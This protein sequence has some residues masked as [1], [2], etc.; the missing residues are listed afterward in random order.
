M[1][2]ATTRSSKQSGLPKTEYF[3]PHFVIEVEGRE[4]RPERKAD[5]TELK[6]SLGIEELAS[7]ELTLSNWD[8][9]KRDFRSDFDVGRVVKVQM[10]YADYL[11]TVFY[12][13]VT[14]LA[15]KF[16]DGAAPTMTVTCLDALIKLRDR[17]P[18]DNESRKYEN[19][20]EVQI[21]RQIAERHGMGF[22]GPATDP[23]QPL[24]LV[25]QKN[26]DDASFLMERAS[27]VDFDCFIVHEADKRRDTLF[28]V[29]PSDGRNADHTQ[30]Y[31]LEYQKNL[32]SFTPQLDVS[33]QVAKVTVRGWNPATKQ[34]ITGQATKNDLPE[35]S[36][37]KTGPEVAQKDFG[38]KEAIVEAPVKSER[39]AQELAVSLL[40]DRAYKFIT[41]DGQM[42][43][44]PNLRPGHNLEIKNVGKL[45]S[46]TYYVKS[47]EHSIGERGYHTSFKVR[48]YYAGGGT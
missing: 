43:G 40:R 34:V 21:A 6:V 18:K 4:V 45:F 3:A 36:K 31:V 26:Q 41:A 7:C 1:T 29:Q 15:P 25:W 5:V 28:F 12:G 47:C 17:Q 38:G 2:M 20:T 16:P 9:E 13:Q 22:V 46:G 19:K 48:K 11:T 42:I 33:D 14:R 44:L 24:P 27:R 23:L 35:G 10:G 8:D 32:S 37:G 30:V 39:E